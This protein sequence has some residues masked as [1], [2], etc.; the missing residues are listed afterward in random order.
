MADGVA[1]IEVESYTRDAAAGTITLSVIGKDHSNR[2]HQFWSVL[3]K[4]DGFGYSGITLICGDSCNETTAV[5][6]QNKIF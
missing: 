5:N 1:A 3:E 4:A 2:E 6:C